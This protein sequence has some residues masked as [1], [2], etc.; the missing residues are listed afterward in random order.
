[1]TWPKNK[2]ASKRQS[3]ARRQHS[4][5]T[6]SDV[7]RRAGVS[8]MT[9][10]RVI[11]GESNVRDITRDAVNQAIDEL[12]YS[13][14]KAARSLASASQ[15]QIGLIYDNP[16]SS[17][18]SAMLLGVL[19]QARQSDTQIV[20]VECETEG[21]GIA[22]IQNMIKTNIDGIILSPPLA[23]SSDVLALLQQ[24]DVLCV[25][26][27]SHHEA[28]DIFSVQIDD[29]QAAA[30]MTRH[31]I[32][33]G[34][35]RIGFICGNPAQQSS[36]ARLNGFR[37]ALAEAGIEA[38]EELIVQ[39]YFTYRSGLEAAEKLLHLE[40]IPTAIFASNDDMAAA[41][42]A[43][44]HRHHVDIPGDLTVCGFDDT[45]LATTIW[46]GITTIRQPIV[47]MSHTAIELLE[48]GIRAKHAG[49]DFESQH[50]TL[51]F[52]LVN[53]QSDGAPPKKPVVVVDAE[54]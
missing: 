1:M 45:L 42:V 31:I 38:D 47:D 20:V 5:A 53:R 25:T 18:L 3:A 11:N 33:L 40:R 51:D 41:T 34:H 14:N 2:L 12:G 30:T 13:P 54:Q 43:T 6:I 39:G 15:I 22:A 4:R 24:H 19:E 35:T 36:A 37:D 50:L 16:S 28:A 48:K 52:A 8:P 32:A 10:S 23:D 29:Y 44:A 26:I 46:P 9:V 7:A 17:F 21:E 49:L 27:G